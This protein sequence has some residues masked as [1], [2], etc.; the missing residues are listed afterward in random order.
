MR[1]RTAKSREI[2]DMKNSKFSLIVLLILS[3]AIILLTAVFALSAYAASSLPQK[4]IILQQFPRNNSYFSSSVTFLIKYSEKNLSGVK[5]N[6]LVKDKL[7]TELNNISY[8]LSCPSGAPAKCEKSISVQE[9]DGKIID[10]SFVVSNQYTSV[11]TARNT[12]FIDTTAPQITISSPVENSI[13][14]TSRLNITGLSTEEARWMKK[15][16]NNNVFTII[17]MR[18]NSTRTVQFFPDGNNMFSIQA[19]DKAGNLANKI[20]SFS[21][22]SRKPLVLSQLPIT[23]RILNGTVNFSIVYTEANLKNVTLFISNSN[24]V[25]LTKQLSCEAGSNKKCST[26]VDLSDYNGTLSYYFNLRDSVNDANSRIVAF[27]VK[28]I[29]VNNN[30]NNTIN[31]TNNSTNNNSNNNFNN[32]NNSTNSNASLNN[33]SSWAY[34]LNT[35]KDDKLDEIKNSNFRLVVIDYSRDGTAS[36]EFARSEIDDLKSSGKIVLAY[37]SI[38]EAEDYRFYWNSSWRAGNPSWLD[39]ENPEWQGNFKVKYWDSGWQSVILGGNSQAGGYLN[40]IM[41][42]GFD[43]VYLDIIDG[44]EYYQDNGISD[45]DRRMVAFVKNISKQAKSRNPNFLIFPQNGEGLS[46]YQ[47]YLDAVD[48]IGI[49]DTWYNEDVPNNPSNIQLKVDNMLKFRNAGKLVLNVDYVS[50][51]S[52]IDDF[53]NK[54]KSLGFVPYATV[55][56]LDRLSLQLLSNSSKNESTAVETT[57]LTATERLKNVKTW[58]YFLHFDLDPVLDNIVNSDYDMVVIE[59]IFTEKENEDYNIRDAVTKIKNSAGMN[60]QNK[61]VIAYIDIGQAESYRY[62]W[63]ENWRVGNPVFIAGEDPDLWEGN[64]PVA[65]WHQEWQDIW[66]E[67]VDGYDAQLK[68]I[69][70]AGFDGVY[71][72]WVEAYSDENVINIANRESKNSIEEMKKFVKKIKDYGINLD[73]D[74]V[75]IA[76][77]AAELAQYDDYIST[78][79]AIAQEQVWFDGSAVG[80]PEGD[81]PLPATD[82]DIETKEYEKSLSEGCLKMYIELPESTLHVSSEEYINNL[83]IAQSKGLTIFTVDYALEEKNIN[84]VHTKSRELGFIPFASNRPLNKFMNPR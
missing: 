22:D 64:F 69:V 3:T 2:K 15:A 84:S 37:M 57:T 79:D 67:G 55:R 36:G 46:V 66:F 35:Y 39:A 52:N 11:Q 65:I 81:C 8:D 10:Y 28:R 61:L 7:G 38:G 76:Q 80:Q 49:E 16:L 60:L 41:D 54:S 73:S 72:D 20:I 24:N 74:F 31:N 34:Q 47:D 56:A 23:N 78:I 27:K 1:Q 17:C 26:L 42:A 48:G 51:R 63:Q 59:P 82:A 4:P 30:Q 25:M 19:L 68:M 40:K 70:D 29:Q 83:K 75:V 13:Y 5:L 45:A 12:I 53:Y 50:T 9:F 6:L 71:L 32:S 33:V 18:C 21:V 58:F 14:N 44:Y 62:Y 43:G 77:N